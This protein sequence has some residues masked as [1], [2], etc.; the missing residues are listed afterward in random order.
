MDSIGSGGGTAGAL[1]RLIVLTDGYTKDEDLCRQLA[2]QA[3]A[4]G[5][6]VSTM[7]IGT[8]FNERLLT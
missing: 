8:D 4:A 2:R 6:A 3:R 5:I 7:G 1:T